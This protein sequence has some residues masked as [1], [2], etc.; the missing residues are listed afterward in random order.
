MKYVIMT[1]EDD[2]LSYKIILTDYDKSNYN[3]AVLTNCSSKVFTGGAAP[4]EELDWWQREIGQWMQWQ[5]KRDFDASSGP[6]GEMTPKLSDIK[7]DWKDKIIAGN[8]QFYTDNK[9]AYKIVSDSGTPKNS[10]GIIN[11]VPDKYKE[12]HKNKKYDFSKY[13]SGAPIA[14]EYG[15]T[16]KRRKFNKKNISFTDNSTGEEN[17]IQSDSSSKYLFDNEDAIVVNFNKKNNEN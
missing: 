11:F 7:Y 8:M 4:I 14:D 16:K 2:H 10:D 12:K 13:I 17:P 3:S 6:N 1:E 5:Y 15:N 9:C